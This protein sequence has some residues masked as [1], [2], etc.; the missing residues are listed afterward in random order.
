MLRRL[1]KSEGNNR[2]GGIQEKA[3]I[4]AGIGCPVESWGKRGA[5]LAQHPAMGDPQDA[6][7]PG[8]VPSTARPQPRGQGRTRPPGAVH[9]GLQ[10]QP[11]QA[12]PGR[13]IF[14]FQ[15]FAI[16]EM[17]SH[18]TYTCLQ[19]YRY[20]HGAGVGLFSAIPLSGH[21]CSVYM[22]IR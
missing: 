13:D 18:R 22:D 14:F 3:G 11:A 6:A 7:R 1:C 15:F 17:L 4:A 19:V 9:G 10:H 16:L 12:S 8:H 21:L 20:A 2:C 5:G